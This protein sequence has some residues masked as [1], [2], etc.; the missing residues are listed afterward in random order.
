M[1]LI[2][3]SCGSHDDY[4]KAPLFVSDDIEFIKSFITK[5]NQLIEKCKTFYMYIDKLIDEK[6]Y[7][8]YTKETLYNLYDKYKDIEDINNVTYIEIKQRNK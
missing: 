1:Y 3:Y 2:E 4:Y 8:L 6:D 5:T 7:S